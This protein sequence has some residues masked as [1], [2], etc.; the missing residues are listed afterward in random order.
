MFEARFDRRATALKCLLIF[1]MAVCADF[2]G[3][4][5]NDELYSRA[6]SEIDSTNPTVTSVYPADGTSDAGIGITVYVNFS[7]DLRF[8]SISGSSFSVTMDGSPVEGDLSWNDSYNRIVFTPSAG[9]NPATADADLQR[10]KTYIVELTESITDIYRNPLAG[11]HSFSF[12]TA[13]GVMVSTIY[14]PG[15]G[16]LTNVPV[17]SSVDIYFI[18]YVNTS[19]GWQVDVGGV[20]YNESSTERTWLDDNGS[21]YYR[22]LRITPS[23][24]FPVSSTVTVDGFSGFTGYDGTAFSGT[25]QSF[26]FTTAP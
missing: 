9:H 15:Y 24:P 5:F 1:F 25:S 19:L 18:D 7:E 17:D 22:R 14:I 2:S 6:A 10:G 13:S 20:T 4:R 8:E 16:F 3:C 26:S 12:S 23:S 11:G 21:G